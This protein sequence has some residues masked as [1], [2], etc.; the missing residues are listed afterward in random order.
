MSFCKFASHLSRMAKF[1]RYDE[2]TYYRDPHNLG[3]ERKFPSIF[4]DHSVTLSVVIPA[5]DEEK[6]LPKMLDECT[7]YLEKKRKQSGDKFTYEIILVDDGSSDRT[8]EV[9]LKYSSKMSSDK[10][11]VLTLKHNR[12]KGGAVRLGFWVTRGKYLLFAD[13]DGATK[14]DDFEKLFDEIKNLEK[15]S[16]DG[17]DDV[18]AGEPI[19]VKT[20]KDLA[21]VV[22][23]RAH[24][25]KESIA[26]RSFFRTVLMLG[27]HFLVWLFCVRTISD[28][29]CGFKLFTRN[30]ARVLFSNLHIERWAFDVELLYLAE[31]LKI[32]IGEVAV[33]WHEVDGSKLTPLAASV[34]MAR[35]LISIWF[36]Y[37]FGFWS[38][39]TKSTKLD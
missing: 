28:T 33:N 36:L 21:V 5:K 23:S 17:D 25:E 9:G 24:L 20:G 12:G 8:T 16:S 26:E 15:T 7:A 1:L 31:R 35:D 22:G 2:E 29:Q 14:F 34:Q 37:F 19:G 39:D 6:R 3:T 13:A 32:P 38:I 27:F 10:F 18:G 30:A 4:D 11:R